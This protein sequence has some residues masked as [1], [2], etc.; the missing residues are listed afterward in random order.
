MYLYGCGGIAVVAMEVVRAQ[1]LAIEG[2]LDDANT[3]KQYRGQHLIVTTRASIDHDCLVGNCVH[4]APNTSICGGVKIGN[5]A[6]IGAGTVVIRD[7]PDHAV[8]AGN[9]AARIIKFNEPP[10]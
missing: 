4:I 1:G 7:V 2:F 9:P 10:R 5:G 3:L 8:V 6:N